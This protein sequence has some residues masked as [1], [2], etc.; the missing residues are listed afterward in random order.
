MHMDHIVKFIG[1][2]LQ[3]L[4]DNVALP[5]PVQ[6]YKL[7]KKFSSFFVKFSAIA[8]QFCSEGHAVCLKF[9]SMQRE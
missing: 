6:K 3:F 8:L 1:Y 4:H 7:F 9:Y 2:I 5:L